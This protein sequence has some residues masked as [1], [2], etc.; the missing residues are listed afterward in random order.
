MTLLGHGLQY[1]VKS[2][3]FALNDEK[4]P[5]TT[6]SFY[7]ALSRM[8][9]RDRYLNE[10][11]DLPDVLRLA[12]CSA[13][14]Y[15]AIKMIADRSTT[16][17]ST[18]RIKRRKGEM[19]QD[20]NDHPFE[21]LLMSPNSLMTGEFL[22]SYTTWWG[23]L[24]GNG[25]IFIAT[26]APGVG[27]PEELWPLQADAV[28]P[29]PATLRISRLTG[30][31]CIDYSYEVNGVL[32]RLPGENVIHI[33]FPN[34]FN[35]WIGMSPLVAGLQALKTDREQ[36]RYLELFYGRD[37]AIPTAIISL[38]PETEEEQFEELKYEIK[39]QFAEGQ[40]RAVIR[41]GDFTIQTIAQTLQQSE[42]IGSRKF[43]REI[44]NHIYSIPEGL[45]SGSMSGD[46][47]LATE[48]AFMRGTVQ[49]WLDRVAA[50][51]T[52][53]A[54]PYYGD[55][56]ICE[57]PNV[58]PQ[59]RTLLVTEYQAYAQDRTINENRKI[60]GLPAWEP[61]DAEDSLLKQMANAPV[62]LITYIS[63]NS[64]QGGSNDPYMTGDSGNIID[65]EVYTNTEQPPGIGDTP[66]LA[67]PPRQQQL[68]SGKASDMIAMVQELKSWR[69]V[70][71]QE[72]RA[73]RNPADR[74]FIS[75]SIPRGIGVTIAHVLNN[76][77]EERVDVIFGNL[78][79]AFNLGRPVLT[80]KDRPQ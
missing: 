65:G 64:Y 32:H 26:E 1:I 40:L 16:R 22:L 50:A 75:R 76:A 79:D 7:T 19:K 44:I 74:P 60:L 46:S 51:M 61:D 2:L 62:R 42:F 31:P 28:K 18:M 53:N 54:C 39:N 69:K 33:R 52:V 24:L 36:A 78:I 68:M 45:L 12:V 77:D 58:V 30:K 29:L 37:N 3:R 73:G 55:D 41:A 27:T 11:V 56:I 80:G 71:R 10:E 9:E 47:R 49:P 34:P 38:P 25:Y 20:I 35:Y 57:A 4:R 48:I 8:A 5:P 63:S 13:W 43:N 67:S 17:E 70:A 72:A 14:V 23:H 66:E 15:S 6:R 59:D 21:R